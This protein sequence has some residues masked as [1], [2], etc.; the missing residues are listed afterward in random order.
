MIVTKQVCG[1]DMMNFQVSGTLRFFATMLT[2]CIVALNR[3]AAL[4][5]PVPAIVRMAT[6]SATV[7]RI[8]LSL[9]MLGATPNR[10][11]DVLRAGEARGRDGECYS[12]AGAGGYRAIAFPLKDACALN[13]TKDVLSLF[14]GAFHA[15]RFS[16]LLAGHFGHGILRPFG[17]G[18]LD[19]AVDII[20]P[21]SV[22]TPSFYFD[23]CVT[24]SANC[25]KQVV[26]TLNIALADVTS[27]VLVVR[28]FDYPTTSA[29]A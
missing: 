24:E 13:R 10:A 18:V 4:L 17:G 25:I 28:M 9:N 27:N 1:L 22:Y 2:G 5:A 29:I 26:S 21:E 11:I 3:Q 20:C 16:A 6:C 15:E 19:G 8:V 7:C 23:G 12:A 14:L